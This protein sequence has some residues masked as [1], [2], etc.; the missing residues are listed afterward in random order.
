M[1]AKNLEILLTYLSQNSDVSGGLP[2]ELAERF[3]ALRSYGRLPRG[4]ERRDHVLKSSEIAAAILGLAAAHPNWAG[5][6]AT[7]LSNLRPVGGADASF[8]GSPTLEE[9][10]EHI[11]TDASALKSVIKLSVSVAESGV[12][13]NG[14]ATLSYEIAGVR[15]RAFFVPEGAVSRLQPGAERDFDPEKLGDILVD[16]PNAKGRLLGEPIIGGRPWARKTFTQSSKSRCC[17]S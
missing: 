11:L 8:F 7:I 6:A 5:H 13:S 3:V 4:R 17:G 1:F 15:H 16:K 12:N 14:Y 10:I 9:S 2:K